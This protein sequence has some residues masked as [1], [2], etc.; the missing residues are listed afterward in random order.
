[1]KDELG[2]PITYARFLP[3]ILWTAAK[4]PATILWGGFY[5]FLREL[6]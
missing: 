5:A 3:T 1:L 4:W 2:R 6:M